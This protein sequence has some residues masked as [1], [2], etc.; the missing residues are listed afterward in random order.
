VQGT[1]VPT[2]WSEA[3]GFWGEGG[4]GQDTCCQTGEI[5]AAIMKFPRTRMWAE[6]LGRQGALQVMEH[7]AHMTP[8]PAPPACCLLDVSHTG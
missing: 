7:T 4:T 5:T 3:G 2:T 1:H 6:V 8:H